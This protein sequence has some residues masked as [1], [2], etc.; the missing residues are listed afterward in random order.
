MVGAGLTGPIAW[1]SRTLPTSRRARP[2]LV[3]D[4][5]GVVPLGHRHRV[6]GATLEA[7]AIGHLDAEGAGNLVLEVRRLAQVGA[8]ER[9]D[10]ARPA[11]TRARA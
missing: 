5:P 10:V 4:H 8:G 1:R 7:A 3:A 9:L 2:A 6:A 11:P